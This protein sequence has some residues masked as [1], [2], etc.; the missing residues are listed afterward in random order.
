MTF[1]LL[2]RLRRN[3]AIEHA[4]LHLLVRKMG[5]VRA[6][7]CSDWGG[8][9]IY[10]DIKT[11]PLAEA[12]IEAL[13]A[14]QSGHAELAIHPHCGSNL[15]VSMFLGTL[16]AATW[17]IAKRRGFWGRLFALGLTIGAIGAAQPLSRIVQGRLLTHPDVRHARIRSVQRY[18]WRG[19]TIH[20]VTIEYE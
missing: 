5:P 10:G 15:T 20:R 4:S 14:L 19:G 3:H 18:P 2:E 7:A 12:A 1:S 16:A 11:Q 9:T 6:V 17:L 13:Q 8:F